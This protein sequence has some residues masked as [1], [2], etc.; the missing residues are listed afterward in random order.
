VIF[1]VNEG[2]K[3]RYL[4][5]PFFSDVPTPPDKEIRGINSYPPR[6]LCVSAI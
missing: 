6:G 2:I 5:D 1:L 4:S 3:Q